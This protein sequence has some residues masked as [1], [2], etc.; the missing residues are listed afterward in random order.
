MQRPV[1]VGCSPQRGCNHATQL[2]PWRQVS[3]AE[4][5]RPLFSLLPT[6]GLRVL[7]LKSCVQGE[8]RGGK[9]KEG[10]GRGCI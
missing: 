5:L 1:T 8:G 9:G 6:R 2:P 4:Q 7:L 10:E 3:P